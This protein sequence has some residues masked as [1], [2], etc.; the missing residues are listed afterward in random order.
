MKSEI[1]TFMCPTC[2]AKV[3]IDTFGEH[4]VCE[5]C[6]NEHT[7][8][9]EKL[10]PLR[11]EVARPSE[12]TI[13]NDSRSARVIQRWF[14]FKYI[15]IAFFA[16]AWDAF[17]IFWYSAALAKGAPWIMVVF[18]IAH[19]AVGVGLTY[20]VLAGFVNRTILEVTP[21]NISVHF[22][23]LPWI[24][25]KKLRTVDLKQLYCKEKIV[26]S[27]N[28]AS[29]QYQLCAITAENTQVKL[30]DGLDNPDTAIFFEQQLECWLK[31]TDR[32]V[33]GEI[34]R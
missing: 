18:P 11:P 28:G 13:Q 25:E 23:P 16:F 12:V 4:A 3:R 10:P 2:G 20:Y 24:G 21:E 19:V 6:G 14:S 30:L 33:S 32:A 17:L 8:N 22:E 26:R 1:T 15:P 27:K 5:Y 31:I 34:P 7:L 9:P 29:T